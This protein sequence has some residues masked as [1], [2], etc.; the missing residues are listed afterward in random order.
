MQLLADAALLKAEMAQRHHQELE[1][2]QEDLDTS[3]E[4]VTANLTK[5]NLENLP[6]WP[7]KAQKRRE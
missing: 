2:F 3:V 1:K 4:S 7:S 6:P 5:M